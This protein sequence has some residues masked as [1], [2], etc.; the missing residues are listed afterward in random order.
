MDK[1]ESIFEKL[2]SVK[3]I[4]SSH[5]GVPKKVLRVAPDF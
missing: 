1:A 5:F 2:S 3:D 4:V